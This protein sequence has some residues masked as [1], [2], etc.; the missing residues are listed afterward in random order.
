MITAIVTFAIPADMT[1]EQWLSVIEPVAARFQNVPG[2]IRKQFL[3]RAGTGGGVY[4][5]ETRAAAE[6]LYQG[7]WRDS[8]RKVA[9]A[10]PE[11]AY[12]DTQIVVDNE[13]DE[14]RIAA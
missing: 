8:V 9:I 10:D 14:V 1:R 3:Y 13:L 5:W 7:A 2:L 11:I 4:L 6:A 12:F